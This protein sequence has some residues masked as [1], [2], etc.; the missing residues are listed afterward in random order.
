MSKWRQAIH[1]ETE[2]KKTTSAFAEVVFASG[3]PEGTRT[4]GLLVRNQTLYPLSYG[5]VAGLSLHGV[6]DL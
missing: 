3:T 1:G 4:P 2:K 6:D 5:R